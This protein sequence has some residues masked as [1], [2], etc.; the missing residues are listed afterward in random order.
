[1]LKI[2]F[3]GFGSRSASVWSSIASFGQCE[4]KAIADPRWE[5]IKG[6]RGEEFPNCAWY[7]DAEEMLR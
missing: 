5:E 4:V 6:A 3:I 7:A 2:G 1:M